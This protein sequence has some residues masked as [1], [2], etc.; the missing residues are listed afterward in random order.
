[1]TVVAPAL[2]G[3]VSLAGAQPL[4]MSRLNGNVP[5][6]P[7]TMQRSASSVAVPGGTHA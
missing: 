2:G 7:S 4:V 5:A 1:V 3:D 6:N